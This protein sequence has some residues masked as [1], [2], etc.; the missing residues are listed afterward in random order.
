M[1]KLRIF[2][3][4]LMTKID[5]FYEKCN[6]M[7]EILVSCVFNRPLILVSVGHFVAAATLCLPPSLPI[8]FSKHLC[9]SK[10]NTTFAERICKKTKPHP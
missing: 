6:N 7:K 3:I 2:L 4:N 8:I 9:R 10:K 1:I 5:V